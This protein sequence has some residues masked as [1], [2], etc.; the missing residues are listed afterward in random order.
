[1]VELM[2]KSESHQ[3]RRDRYETS[4]NPE[5]EYADAAQTVLRNHEG[6]T[7]LDTLSL[8]E[9]A[10]HAQAYDSLLRE[11]RT[12][13]RLTCELI[14]HVHGTI[15]GPLFAWAGRWRTVWIRKPG[16]TWPAPDFLE[17]NMLAYER[18][19]LSQ[20]PPEALREEEAFCRAVGHIQGEFLVIH[21]FREGNARTIKLAT[22]LLALQT[23]RLPLRYDQSPAGVETYIAAAQAAFK[24]DYAAMA[25]VIRAA[26]QRR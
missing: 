7:D 2:A 23:G 9:Q 10:L 22:D 8:R 26:L 18:E 19:V 4:R 5:A 3:P 17:Q 11:V 14:Q 20:Y 1:M 12:D 16:V 21:P 24:Q 6:I 25:D 13:T 15:F